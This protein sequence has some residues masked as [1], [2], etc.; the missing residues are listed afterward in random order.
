MNIIRLAI[1]LKGGWIGVKVSLI[2][3]LKPE[4]IMYEI[5]HQLNRLLLRHANSLGNNIWNTISPNLLVK[6]SNCEHHNV[7]Y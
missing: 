5:S 3:M 2:K 4:N 1:Y 7:Y 6:L